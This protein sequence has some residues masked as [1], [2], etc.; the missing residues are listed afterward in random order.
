MKL[1]ISSC[2]DGKESDLF[3]VMKQVELARLHAMRAY[4]YM[5]YFLNR[6]ASEDCTEALV[7]TEDK[8]KIWDKVNE[9]VNAH[10]DYKAL[11][12]GIDG[13]KLQRM[14]DFTLKGLL[15]DRF[16]DASFQAEMLYEE[17]LEYLD[18]AKKMVYR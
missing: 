3:E 9:S 14:L 13:K 10:I 8:R 1:E 4:P 2:V 6:S 16:L 17:S 5:Q 12:E 18:M 11:P 15:A 7:S